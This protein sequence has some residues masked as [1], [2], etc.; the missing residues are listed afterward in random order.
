MS[1]TPFA[2]LLPLGV[3][4][5][6]LVASDWYMRRVSTRLGGVLPQSPVP[7]FQFPS[8]WKQW[9]LRLGQYAGALFGLWI[10]FAT[11]SFLAHIV[12]LAIC[13]EFFR[14]AYV[15]RIK[16]LMA[17]GATRRDLWTFILGVSAFVISIAW[18]LHDFIN[19]RYGAV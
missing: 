19:R 7:A 13:A 4:I 18:F 15:H 11:N 5:A 2:F 12:L 10:L 9:S 8:G 14:R 3:A 6:G 16:P 17:L 1:W